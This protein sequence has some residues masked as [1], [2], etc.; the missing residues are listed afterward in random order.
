MVYHGNDKRWFDFTIQS[1]QS[2]N[3]VSLILVTSCIKVNDTFEKIVVS[4][5]YSG[6]LH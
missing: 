5:V 3:I 6:F 1:I 4:S 2:S